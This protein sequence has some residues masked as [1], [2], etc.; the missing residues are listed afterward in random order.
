MDAHI[1]WL[2]CTMSAAY[3]NYHYNVRLIAF[4]APE[5]MILSES[6]LPPFPLLLLHSPSFSSSLAP[7]FYA[8]FSWSLP[9]SS[10]AHPTPV[11]SPSFPRS[12]ILL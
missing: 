10:L 4:Q 6:P 2:D 12:L 1:I 9:F 5:S 8:P 11:M 7:A 3:C